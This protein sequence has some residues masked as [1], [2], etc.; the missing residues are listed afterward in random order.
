MKRDIV[1]CLMWC[2]WLCHTHIQNQVEGGGNSNVKCKES[3]KHNFHV[4]WRVETGFGAGK[5]CLNYIISVKQQQQR[6]WQ[7]LQQFCFFFCVSKSFGCDIIKSTS[8]KRY[9][10]HTHPRTNNI[11][12]RVEQKKKD[13]PRINAYN[14]FKSA[15]K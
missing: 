2:T 5:N 10:A 1:E 8:G 7:L 3:A 12:L 9:S 13:Q 14:F 6:N 11:S 15:T 4:A